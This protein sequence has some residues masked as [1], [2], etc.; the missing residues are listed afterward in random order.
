MDPS[1]GHSKLDMMVGS[2]LDVV[3]SGLHRSVLPSDFG[4][5]WVEDVGMVHPQIAW[6]PTLPDEVPR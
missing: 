4:G 5:G 2:R 1:V 3:L 6:A